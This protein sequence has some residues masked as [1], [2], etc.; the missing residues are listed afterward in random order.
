MEWR[1][2]WLPCVALRLL[3]VLGPGYIH[4]DE[5]FQGPEV[6]LGVLGGVQGLLP[7]EFGDPPL[8]SAAPMYGARDRAQ[9]RPL[10]T[11]RRLLMVHAV[12]G[13]FDCAFVSVCVRWLW[14]WLWTTHAFWLRQVPPVGSSC[15]CACSRVVALGRPGVAVVDHGRHPWVA[16]SAVCGARW[17]H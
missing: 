6:V 4:P 15:G 8:R 17:V 7:W 12:T 10:H 11:N 16:V 3:L 14:L 2:L 5:V 1:A 13:K 9:G